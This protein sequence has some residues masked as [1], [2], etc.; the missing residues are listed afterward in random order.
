MI[1][2]RMNKNRIENIENI[3]S[4]LKNSKQIIRKNRSNQIKEKRLS[5][6]NMCIIILILISSHFSTQVFC[7]EEKR[8]Q[9]LELPNT[10]NSNNNKLEPIYWSANNKNFHDSSNSG[11]DY[12]FKL[13]AHIGDSIDLVCAQANDSLTSPLSSYFNNNNIDNTNNDEPYLYSVIYR[14][15]TKHEFDNCI[16]DP[17]NVETVPIL[18]CDKPHMK[19]TI[20]FTIYFVKFSPVPNALEFE[21]GKEY[22]FLSTSSGTRN[23]LNYMSGGL[24]SKYNM[25]FSIKIDSQKVINIHNNNN[26]LNQ[27]NSKSSLLSKMISTK[28]NSDK[29]N[30]NPV[31]SNSNNNISHD[32]DEQTERDEQEK[33]PLDINSNQNTIGKESRYQFPTQT[34]VSKLNLVASRSTSN[35]NI[36]NIHF[37][38]LINYLLLTLS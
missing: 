1:N 11:I 34:I 4:I 31:S 38:F 16:I 33:T 3:K 2:L 18:K 9:N 19:N 17:N 13:N 29:Q 8:Q 22:Y 7:Y 25:R 12:F 28:F 30:F 23:G 37:I 32:E 36:C 24:C 35:Y 20:K 14:V 6:F 26:L 27:P 21:E 15:A 5:V 10:S